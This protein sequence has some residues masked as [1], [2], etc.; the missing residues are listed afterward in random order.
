M[1]NNDNDLPQNAVRVRCTDDEI[2][3]DTLIRHYACSKFSEEE[4]QFIDGT[5]WEDNN[6]YCEYSFDPRVF[7]A[8]I[9][10]ESE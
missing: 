1:S 10:S 8:F 5:A 4:R 7:Q 3:F 9:W 2:A 6:G